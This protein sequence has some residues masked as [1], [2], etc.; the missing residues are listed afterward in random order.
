MTKLAKMLQLHRVQHSLNQTELAT[1]IGI[2]P[3][4]VSAI[5]KGKQ[6]T[7]EEMAKFNI[8]VLS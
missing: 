4:R 6:P 8:W 5:E 3:R 2:D 1:E 7:A